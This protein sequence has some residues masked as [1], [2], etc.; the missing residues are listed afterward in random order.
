ML[1]DDD[2]REQDAGRLVCNLGVPQ[3]YIQSSSLLIGGRTL[4]HRYCAKVHVPIDRF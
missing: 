1:L 3:H 4:L 2:R